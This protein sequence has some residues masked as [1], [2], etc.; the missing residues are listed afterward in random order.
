PLRGGTSRPSPNVAIL[1]NVQPKGIQFL[2]AHPV[3]AGRTKKNGAPYVMSTPFMWT[4][5]PHSRNT[6]FRIK[7]ERS[8]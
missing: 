7:K 2:H 3:Y 5:M 8:L 4:P 6:A 1:A